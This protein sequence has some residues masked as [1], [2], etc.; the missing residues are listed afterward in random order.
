M[1]RDLRLDIHVHL[2]GVG[3]G[4]S[5][6]WIS[7]RFR[8]RPSFRV[9]CRWH[10][11]T[12]E[13]MRASVDQDWVEAVA[14]R[15]RES[16][17]D[18]AVVLGFDG[19]YDERGRLD[20]AR[21]Q[22]VVPP[23]WVLEACRRHPDELLPG[24]SLNPFRRDADERLD[25]CIEGGAV[26]IKWLP[27]SQGIDPSSPRL[28]GFY[29][30]L[31]DVGI[32]LLI[33]AGSGESTFR[34]IEPSLKDL[35]HLRAPLEAGVSVICAH[36]GAPVAMRRELDQLPLLRQM[37]AEYP[38]LW[39]DNSGMAN[40]TRCRYLARLARDPEFRD[41]TLHGSDFPVPS[42][43]FYFVKGLGFR[44]TWELDHVQNVLDRD[45]RIKRALGYPDRC[46][47]MATGVIANLDRW[48]PVP[49]PS[50]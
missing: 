50:V 20:I 7:P 35:R 23:S 10:G 21:S 29:Q 17:L 13:Q 37:L 24:P 39:L 47:T 41:R 16:E 38:H 12:R 4:D 9:L 45:V 46:L 40:P 48:A 14:G 42:N 31:A 33:H 43:A 28:A 30:K 27:A 22:M 6:C 5:G 49:A 2:A 44:Q 18:R 36:S 11:I 25:E 32:P 19:A 8:R 34:E 1:N 3:T 15:I 26:L